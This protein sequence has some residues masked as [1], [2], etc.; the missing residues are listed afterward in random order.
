MNTASHGVR[1][2]QLAGYGPSLKKRRP[3][4]VALK[5]SSLQLAS[6]QD[7]FGGPP[8]GG[9]QASATDVANQGFSGG[10]SKIPY[11]SEMEASFGGVDF[12][13]VKAHTGPAAKSASGA[14]GAQAY[15]MGNQV[16]FG[17]DNPSK[18]LVAHELTHVLQQTG[19]S[20]RRAA[21]HGDGI[22]VSGEAEANAVE[23]A[24]AS[25]RTAESALTG[26]AKAGGVARKPALNRTTTNT[27]GGLGTSFVIDGNALASGASYDIWSRS[28]SWPTPIPGLNVIVNPAVQATGGSRIATDGAASVTVGIAGSVGIGASLGV[29]NGV[30]GYITVG[31][32]L[33]ASATLARDA[34]GTQTF[35][36][37]AEIGVSGRIGV[38]IAGTIDLGINLFN[39]GLLAIN[40]VWS[41]SGSGWSWDNARSGWGPGADM[42]TIWDT[43]KSMYEGLCAVAR[44]AVRVA[45]AAAGAVA[46]V[47]VGAY[48]TAGDVVDWVA[49]W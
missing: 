21:R 19:G 18:S 34:A 13:D 8:G 9:T 28:I 45:S 48:E 41:N 27:S 35:T 24:V 20:G 33:T 42:V 32:S 22:D 26:A 37:G 14:L 44:G 39:C 29:A 11:Q 25:G 1:A 38:K 31:P 23:S 4:Q 12:S 6:L 36:L 16:S 10:G 43:L 2:G 46:D 15:A 47:A 3:S 30:E 49:S 40:A 7:S 17:T 5:P